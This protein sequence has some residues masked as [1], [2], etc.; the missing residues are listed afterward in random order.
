MLLF[1]LLMSNGVFSSEE[2]EKNPVVFAKFI[3][4]KFEN[5]NLHLDRQSD[6]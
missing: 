6:C 3:K 2:L 5:V 1:I 4:R